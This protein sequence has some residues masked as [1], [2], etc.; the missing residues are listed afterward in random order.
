ACADFFVDDSHLIE[1]NGPLLSYGVA[2]TDLD[3]NNVPEF[4]VTGVGY[5][6]LALE[7]TGTRLL[8]VMAANLAGG[9]FSD[10]ERKTIGVSACDVDGDGREEVYFLNTDS[11]SGEKL[12]ADR[13]LDF[14][15]GV[16]D[17]F[18]QGDNWVSLNLTAGRSVACVDRE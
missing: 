10:A 3:G 2:V 16:T 17:L 1:S 6:N 13:L 12:L 11:Y 9:L 4:I 18:A 15:S 14:D 5:P 7:F 8:D